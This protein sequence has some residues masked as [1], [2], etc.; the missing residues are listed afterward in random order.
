[1]IIQRIINFLSALYVDGAKKNQPKEIPMRKINSRGISLLKLYEGCKL[2]SY[3]DQ[4]GILTIGYG[5][6]GPDVKENQTITQEQA[7]QLLELDLARF[8]KGVSE[9]VTVSIN[10]SE[11]SALVCL[12]YNIGLGN[13]SRSTLLKKL[14]ENNKEDAANQFLVWNHINGVPS[15]GLSRRR[16]SERALFLTTLD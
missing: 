14:N 15:D 13:L 16:L 6:T 12:A 4:G 5:H 9:L 11:F 8:E 1:M 2:Y 3:K 7:D 10:E